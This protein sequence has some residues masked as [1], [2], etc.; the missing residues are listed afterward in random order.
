[1]LGPDLTMGRGRLQHLIPATAAGIWKKTPVCTSG[2]CG[3]ILTVNPHLQIKNVQRVLEQALGLRTQRLT[4]AESKPRSVW[5]H[6]AWPLL[7]PNCQPRPILTAAT[8]WTPLQASGRSRRALQGEEPPGIGGR[9]R[10]H[11]RSS[12]C[13]RSALVP[14]AQLL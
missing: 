10:S 14:T 5:L 6:N 3:V 1:M 9:G 8:S 2:M 11:E 7:C 13:T 12:R 4:N